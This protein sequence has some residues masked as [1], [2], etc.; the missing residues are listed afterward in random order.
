MQDRD[1]LQSERIK[2]AEDVGAGVIV[3]SDTRRAER[4]PPNQ[5]R[6]KK[7]PGLDAPRSA[8]DRPRPL[9]AWRQRPGEVR[10][11][12][13]P[14]GVPSA[15]PR[16]GL[17]RHALRHALVAPGKRVGGSRDARDSE[18]GGSAPPGARRRGG[19]GRPRV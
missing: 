10:A 8:P 15:S 4:L 18:A 17:R 5:A 14:E 2:T 1:K 6:T 13:R 16:P 3:S 7:G 19:W 11:L 9:D 12:L